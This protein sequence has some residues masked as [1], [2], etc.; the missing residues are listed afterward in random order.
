LH[1]HEKRRLK[2]SKSTTSSHGFKVVGYI[3]R[4]YNGEV[5]EKVY[6]PRDKVK[7]T[8]VS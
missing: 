4:D 6:K 1:K 3:I 5:L 8:D 7:S 2:D